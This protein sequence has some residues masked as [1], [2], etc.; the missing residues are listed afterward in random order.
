MG[1]AIIR[2]PNTKYT[3]SIGACLEKLL[4]IMKIKLLQFNYELCNGI[5]SQYDLHNI[6]KI[7][8]DG[9]PHNQIT[10]L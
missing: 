5:F 4:K 2:S 6:I 3:Q 7:F 9:N 8:I 1:V 10:K